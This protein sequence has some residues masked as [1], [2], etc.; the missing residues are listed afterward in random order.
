[1]DTMLTNI[2]A[3]LVA[4]A[5]AQAAKVGGDALIDAYQGLK[6]LVIKKLGQSG[7]VQSVEDKPKS[8]NAQG[9]LVEAIADAGVASDDELAKAAGAVRAAIAA[10]S[11][12][13]GKADINIKEVE[14]QVDAI[15]RN[16]IASGN[17]V[18]ERVVARTGNATVSDLKAGN[19]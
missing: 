5:T 17:I 10:D 9:S 8:T 6:A 3:A 7:A 16:L 14:G 19:T 18:I 11:S 15:V 1:M 2:V 13:P 12:I 4:G